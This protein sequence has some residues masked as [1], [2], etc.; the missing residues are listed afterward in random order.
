VFEDPVDRPLL[1]EVMEIDA[2]DD[3][4][5]IEDACSFMNLEIFGDDVAENPLELLSCDI[6]I[7]VTPEVVEYPVDDPENPTLPIGD[8]KM[9]KIRLFGSRG[10]FKVTTLNIQV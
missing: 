7:V 10:P 3:D 5:P 4:V 1:K 9:S 2:E 6:M 8:R